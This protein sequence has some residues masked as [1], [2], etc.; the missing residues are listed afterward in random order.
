[1]NNVPLTKLELEEVSYLM[2]LPDAET[3]YIQQKI[4]R[5]KQPYEYAM[6]RDMATHLTDRKSV[7]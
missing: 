4:T 3:D 1:M 5:D 7:V 2:H 6:L